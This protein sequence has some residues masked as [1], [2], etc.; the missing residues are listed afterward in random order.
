MSGKKFFSYKHIFLKNT[1]KNK[2]FTI[3]SSC[4]E[5]DIKFY[6]S[7]I[8]FFR[9]TTNHIDFFRAYIGKF[10]CKL[11]CRANWMNEKKNGLLWKVWEG[12]FCAFSHKAG[13]EH[14]N[15]FAYNFPAAT[16]FVW[17]CVHSYAWI[18]EAPKSLVANFMY[19]TIKHNLTQWNYEYTM[20]DSASN[21]S[22]ISES[23]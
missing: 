21:T 4:Y 12:F 13:L 23:W 10:M 1:M 15:H 5:L 7:T 17:V 16:M 14:L 22:I 20:E 19:K 18:M 6:F 9:A 11:C 8:P 2:K 3:F